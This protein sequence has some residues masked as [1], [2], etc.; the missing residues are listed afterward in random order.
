MVHGGARG[1]GAEPLGE[2]R[3]E[4]LLEREELVLLAGHL[5]G[6]HDPTGRH[7]DEAH[8]ETELRIDRREGAGDGIA[9][10]DELADPLRRRGVDQLRALQLQLAEDGLELLALDDRD[11]RNGR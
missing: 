8:V 4:L 2:L 3:D 7:L 6:E 10:T 11:A 9:G 1:L 5:L